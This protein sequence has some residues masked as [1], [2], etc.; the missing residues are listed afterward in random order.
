MNK[1]ESPVK[2]LD[3][4]LKKQARPHEARIDPKTRFGEQLAAGAMAGVGF[5]ETQIANTFGLK[6]T[7]VKS[8]LAH[9]DTQ[10]FVKAVREQ[11]KVL[12]SRGILK[13]TKASYKWLGEVAKAKEDPK[14]FA[15][16]TSGIANMEKVSASLSGESRP[17]TTIQNAVVT[18]QDVSGELKELLEKLKS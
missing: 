13:A 1:P 10:E 5:G 16:I 17:Q 4:T 9:P 3:G 7:H 14:A 6:R 15:A 11:A 12:G 2:W 18:A 8:L